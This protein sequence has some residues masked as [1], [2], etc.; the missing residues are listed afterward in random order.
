MPFKCK[1]HALH[2]G[3]GMSALLA[4]VPAPDN[5]SGHLD[6]SIGTTGCLAVLVSRAAHCW[7]CEAAGL[8]HL[9]STMASVMRSLS[10]QKVAMLS[11]QAGEPEG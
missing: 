1:F 2:D 7:Y 4:R 11:Y 8:E 9:S 10:W 5:R 3:W 6:R